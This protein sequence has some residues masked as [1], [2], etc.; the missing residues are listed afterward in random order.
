MPSASSVRGVAFLGV[1][2]A[3]VAAPTAEPAVALAG[4]SLAAVAV[5]ALTASPL[6]DGRVARVRV[7]VRLAALAGHPAGDLSAASALASL[8]WRPLLVAFAPS[9]LSS[10]AVPSPAALL[11][12]LLAVAGLVSL[13]SALAAV[14]ARLV[15]LL[16]SGP[17]VS[18]LLA[19]LS[20][21][22]RYPGVG[23]LCQLLVV[24]VGVLALVAVV[25]VMVV[26]M[27]L[28]AALVAVA[29]EVGP[30]R[31]VALPTLVKATFVRRFPPFL[32][33]VWI[34]HCSKPPRRRC[35][36][37]SLDVL[38][39][40]QARPRRDRLLPSVAILRQVFSIRH[41]HGSHMNET[42]VRLVCPECGKDWEET[43]DDLPSHDATFNCPNCHA[44]RR[45]AEFA[46]TE[47]DLE[48]L[49]QFQ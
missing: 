48:T 15:A 8:A 22:A 49:K 46:R 35:P 33:F 32:L 20:M 43:P 3:S 18:V 19:R 14:T 13:G 1:A 9:L 23:L 44:S 27:M 2:L 30:V 39:D 6:A 21:T 37:T 29:G 11:S 40:G 4:A 7:A 17:V 5:F 36:R 45:T 31:M 25:V 26:V 47:K 24:A 28:V 41:A 34:S 38:A 12:A 42:Y 10:L 16:T